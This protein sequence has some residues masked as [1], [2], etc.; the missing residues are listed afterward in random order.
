MWTFR[1]A[2]L[3]LLP[4]PT[5]RRV[6]GTPIS[7]VHLC[8]FGYFGVRVSVR[9]HGDGFSAWIVLLS[10]TPPRFTLVCSLDR[11]FVTP[12]S[13][14]RQAPLSA[15]S[16]GESPGC[17]LLLRGPSR[18]AERGLLLCSVPFLFLDYLDFSFSPPLSFLLPWVSVAVWRLV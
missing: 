4:L 9:L 10:T 2:S 3:G 8:E 7:T 13:I 12:A 15:G 17:C 14:A 18:V 11:P 6:P 1:P 5:A 16:A